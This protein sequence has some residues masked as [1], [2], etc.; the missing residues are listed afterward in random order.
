VVLT[1][2]GLSIKS[3]EAL[4]RFNDVM[5]EDNLLTDHNYGK[6]AQNYLDHF[7]VR[8]LFTQGDFRLLGNEIVRHSAATD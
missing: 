8:F 2:L 3:G 7:G 4:G 6:I 1:P 5:T